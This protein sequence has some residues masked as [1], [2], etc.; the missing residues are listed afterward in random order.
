MSNPAE[1]G[2]VPERRNIRS[3][4]RGEA[5]GRNRRRLCRATGDA[6]RGT[7][8]RGA[9]ASDIANPLEGVSIHRLVKTMPDG[10]LGTTAPQS[11]DSHPSGINSLIMRELSDAV[12]DSD[13][14]PYFQTAYHGTP[15][16]FNDKSSQ[17]RSSIRGRMPLPIALPPC[18]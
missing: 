4:V 7:E 10:T 15:H 13:D 9:S 2:S 1:T 6:D 18:P 11:P 16:R 8:E 3:L 12:N 5:P 17:V 14:V